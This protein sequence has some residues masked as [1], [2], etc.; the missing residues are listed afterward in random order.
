VCN[1]TQDGNGVVRGNYLSVFLELSDGLPETSKF[2]YSAA[3]CTHRV[4]DK[5]LG[6][7]TGCMR[8]LKSHEFKIH[9]PTCKGMENQPNGCPILDPCTCIRL[10]HTLSFFTFDLV[11]LSVELE[12]LLIVQM[13]H[14]FAPIPTW[15]AYSAPQEYS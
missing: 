11:L 6:L 9:F 7:S 2:V 3:F 10:S 1:C 14:F 15:E 4:Q 5:R 12:I 8:I 13:L